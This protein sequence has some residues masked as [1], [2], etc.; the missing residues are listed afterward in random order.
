MQQSARVRAFASGE[1]LADSPAAPR[2]SSGA[3]GVVDVKLA[4]NAC[5]LPVKML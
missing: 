4:A 5:R 3:Y 2:C 1:S